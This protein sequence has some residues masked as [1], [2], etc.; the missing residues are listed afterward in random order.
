[1]VILSEILLSSDVLQYHDT[2]D[3]IRQYSWSLYRPSVL[4]DGCFPDM[5]MAT[6]F[7]LYDCQSSM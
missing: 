2:F 6:C 7:Q 4:F 5:A 1:M 3:M